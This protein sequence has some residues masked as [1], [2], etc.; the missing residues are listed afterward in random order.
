[1]T[2]VDHFIATISGVFPVLLIIALVSAGLWFAH[3]FFFRRNGGLK[4]DDRFSA[5]V[6]MLVLVGIGG[7]WDCPYSPGSSPRQ[8]N[9]QRSVPTVGSVTHRG[10]YPFFHNVR[11]ECLGGLHVARHA[12]FL[13]GRFSS[14]GK[15]IRPGHRTGRVSYGNTN[16]RT[17]SDHPPKL[18]FGVSPF[19]RDSLLR[20]DGLGYGIFRI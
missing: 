5:R 3:W 10:H 18:I 13:I 8:G 12:K 19:Y 4:E 6:G 9:P 11:F 16:R 1:M 14:R 2:L 17:R 15:S 7:H 20:N